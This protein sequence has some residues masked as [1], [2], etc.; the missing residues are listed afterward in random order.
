MVRRAA[1]PP[2][3]WK[4]LTES[5]VRLAASVAGAAFA[6]TLMFM[7]V[8]FRG[9]LLDSMVA[10]VRALDG[11]L[12][13]VSQGLY[14]LGVPLPIPARRLEQARAFEGVVGASPLYVETRRGRWRN[15]TDGLPRR[16][17]ILAAP[18]GERS[19]DFIAPEAYEAL[20]RPDTLV[21]DALSK[22]GLY[23]TF[24]PGGSSELS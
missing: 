10:V 18:P 19:L 2:L 16:I 8:G 4:N 22:P 9:A 6:V 20:E 11:E 1:L 15:P 12:F 23:G 17:R 24:H 5:P 3:A 21:A 7:E 13:L 14:T